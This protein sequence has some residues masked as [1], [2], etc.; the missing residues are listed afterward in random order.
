MPRINIPAV[1]SLSV[2][3]APYVGGPVVEGPPRAN[4]YTPKLHFRQRGGTLGGSHAPGLM[5]LTGVINTPDGG[6]TDIV[7]PRR[8]RTFS[9]ALLAGPPP[10]PFFP[11]RILEAPLVH[12]GRM[13]PVIIGTC[14]KGTDRPTTTLCSSR[15]S[16]LDQ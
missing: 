9:L 3:T 13:G 8:P 4:C 2:C 6:V 7:R 15:N 11:L 12:G 5:G 14:K 16:T 1:S 10:P